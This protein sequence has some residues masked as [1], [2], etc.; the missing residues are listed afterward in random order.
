MESILLREG[1]FP[2]LL[3]RPVNQF[4]DIYNLINSANPFGRLS[5][6]Y[7]LV[8]NNMVNERFIADRYDREQLVVTRRT[9]LW[10]LS[11]AKDKRQALSFYASVYKNS[12]DSLKSDILRYM[13]R[14]DEKFYE[15]FV[16]ENKVAHALIPE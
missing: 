4:Y 9:L 8:E 16:K 12:D 13:K 15:G 7:S 11:Y 3:S 6:Y 14:L 5:G 1:R 10:V 2:L